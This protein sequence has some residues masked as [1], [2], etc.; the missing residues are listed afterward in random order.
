MSSSY[1]R[2]R[3]SRVPPMATWWTWSRPWTCDCRF[4]LRVS[5]QRAGR[6]RRRATHPTSTS[7]GLGLI[8]GPNPPPTSGVI[9]CTCSGSKP[10][11][12]AMVA[13]ALCGAWLEIHCTSRSPSHTAADPRPS[14]DTPATRWLTTR[15]RTTTSQPS[16]N[17]S[18]SSPAPPPGS[19]APPA[20][21]HPRSWMLLTLVPTSGNSTTSSPSAGSIPMTAGS[22]SM[23]TMTVSDASTAW[24]TESATT[25]ATGSPTNRTVSAANHGRAIPA[26]AP[27]PPGPAGTRSRSAAVN[28]ARTPGMVS[29]SATSTSTIRPWANID[30]TTTRCAAPS[31]RGSRR[32]SR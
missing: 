4:S 2:T 6:P 1:A 22:G 15:A 29:V 9:T 32:S 26:G 21:A 25:T 8:L 18:A 31:S 5:I 12:L 28:T 20:S 13:R 7:S 30:R 23:S 16:Q 27:M 3:P 19:D 17:S 11:A 14:R 10:W 24:A